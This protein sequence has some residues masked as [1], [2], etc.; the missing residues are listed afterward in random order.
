[1]RTILNVIW[2]VFAGIWLAIGYAVAGVICCVLIVTI[3]FGIASFR[4]AAYALWPF[5][6]T[7]ERDPD[8]GVF[9]LLGNIIWLVVAGIWLAIGHVITSIPLFI[10]IIGI[11]LGVANLKLVPVSLL[12]LGARIVDND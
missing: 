6:R 11:P 7:V 8:A 1:M 9:S 5:G 12:P 2:L 4:I 3:P 10:S